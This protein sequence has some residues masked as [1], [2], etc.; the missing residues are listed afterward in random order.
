VEDLPI[1]E[2]DASQNSFKLFMNQYGGPA[3]VQRANQVQAALDELVARCRKRRDDLLKMVK[4]HLGTLQGLAGDWNALRPFVT[5]EDQLRLLEDL[6][7]ALEPSLRVPVA[8]TSSARVLRRTLRELIGSLERF[9]R[10]WQSYLHEVDVSRVNQLRDGYNRYYVLEKECVVRSPR[11]ARL[12]FRPLEPL[13]LKE[14]SALL[15]TLPIPCL[16]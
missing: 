14:L 12:G 10:R 1:V 11:L 5:D 9:N 15:P 13:A 3:F 2:H 16:V 8:P 6:Y 7:A 4:I